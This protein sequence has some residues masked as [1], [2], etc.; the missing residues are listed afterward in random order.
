MFYVQF[1]WT[2]C[3][4]YMFIVCAGWVWVCRL[5]CAA[6][7][8]A[9]PAATL[10]MERDC[11][12]PDCNYCKLSTQMSFLLLAFLTAGTAMWTHKRQGVTRVET[13]NVIMSS[14]PALFSLLLFSAL[15]SPQVAATLLGQA[16]E[17]LH[18]Q[19]DIRAAQYQP[20]LC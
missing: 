13:G 11:R 8:E 20:S 6:G 9:A 18:P 17:L 2:I 10:L 4:C 12:P 5:H 16:G 7:L 14:L 15:L 1:K 3:V 19:L